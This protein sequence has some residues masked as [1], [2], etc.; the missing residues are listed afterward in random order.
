ML[1]QVF[2]IRKHVR[3][4]VYLVDSCHYKVSERKKE[5]I[6]RIFLEAKEELKKL[7]GDEHRVCNVSVIT[8]TEHRDY[9]LEARKSGRMLYLGIEVQGH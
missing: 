1:Y 3:I 8:T 9:V 7:D 5:R 6:Q 2:Q 4:V